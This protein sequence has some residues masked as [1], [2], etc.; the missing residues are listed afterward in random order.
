VDGEIRGILVH[1]GDVYLRKSVLFA[2]R[3][4]HN[5]DRI[6]AHGDPYPSLAPKLFLREK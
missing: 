3:H 2:L 5:R 1:S 4:L 6:Q